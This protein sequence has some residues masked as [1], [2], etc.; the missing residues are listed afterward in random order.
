MRLGLGCLTLGAL[1]APSVSSAQEEKAK[2]DIL[3]RID[4]ALDTRFRYQ[5]IQSSGG[6][7]DAEALTLR[8]RG[9]VEI[10]L[11]HRTRVLGEIEAV[12]AFIE[13]FDDGTEDLSNN[14]F[15]PDPEGIVLNRLK[16]VSEII[17]KTRTTLG[18]QRIALDDWRFFGA[19]AFRQNDQTADAIRAETRAFDFGN[20]TGL[21]DVG[22]INRINRPLGPNNVVGTFTGTS[23][24][25]N[26]GVT[27][28]I[29]RVGAFHYDFS[30]STPTSDNSTRTTGVRVLGRRHSQN[31]GVIW[32]ASYARQTDSRGNPEDFNV[33]YGLGILSVEPGDW[34]FTIRGEELGSQ[35]GASL[36]TPLASLHRFS[37]LADQFLVTP[38][39]GLRDLSAAV[40][41]DIGKIGPFEKI[42]LKT[43]AHHFQD[44]GGDI[45][46]GNE[47]DFELSAGIGDALIS[48][49]HARYNA[50]NFSTN[51][52]STVVSVSYAFGN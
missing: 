20:E 9:S 49:E 22:V 10:D 25:A 3:D 28:P 31:F 11:G 1:A 13:D 44:A 52:N 12:E 21:L 15:I 32:E 47:I 4:F 23:W 30:L 2:F 48:L 16:L 50:D 34:G 41:R 35:N 39:E 43:T 38:P 7:P 29:G 51:T 27:T 42:Q 40:K 26:Y 14:A 24:Y 5:T 17:P 46:Y 6:Q 19:F 45:T 33:G 8:A 18:R 37:G 36:Q